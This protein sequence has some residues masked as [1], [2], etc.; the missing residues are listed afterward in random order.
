MDFTKEELEKMSKESL[1]R[2]ILEQQED[3]EEYER[4]CDDEDKREEL[5]D[6]YW[7]NK[8]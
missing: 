2:I 1:I 5:E 8:I 3:I 7:I 6:D 4:L